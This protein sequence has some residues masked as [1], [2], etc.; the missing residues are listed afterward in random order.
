MSGCF[1][2]DRID[3]STY[4]L[5]EYRHWEEAHCYLLCESEHGL[6]IDMGLGIANIAVC[7]FS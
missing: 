5:S 6:L 3:E 1:A 2:V 7:E 4:I